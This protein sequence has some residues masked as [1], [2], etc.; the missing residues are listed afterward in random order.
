MVELIHAPSKNA[1]TTDMSYIHISI[2][3]TPGKPPLMEFLYLHISLSKTTIHFF[4]IHT[5]DLVLVA[6]LAILYI[7][8]P[9]FSGPELLVRLV[10]LVSQIP[11]HFSENS[12]PQSK[13]TI[14]HIHTFA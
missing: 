1:M 10:R 6:P 7:S 4:N 14:V 12:I 5:S 2:Y 3:L 8:C 11:D 9:F 13:L